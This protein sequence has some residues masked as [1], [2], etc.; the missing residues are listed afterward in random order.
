MLHQ[1]FICLKFKILFLINYHTIFCQPTDN[2]VF[3]EKIDNRPLKTVAF[4][5]DDKFLVV[6]G[7]NKKII[8]YDLKKLKVI[9]KLED[10]LYPV[11][12]IRFF[13][14]NQFFVAIGPN[15]YL[16][17]INNN[18]IVAFRGY[19]TY[20]WSFD[21][22]IPA[23]LV[24][25]GSYASKVIVWDLVYGNIK[26]NLKGH[27]ESVLSVAI[28]PDGNK[29]LTG[30]LDK[31][32]CLWSKEGNLIKKK[33][34]HNDNIMSINFHPSGRYF[35][36][37]S[38]DKT[39]RL[40]SVDSLNILNTIPAEGESVI[41]AILS[42]DGNHV[43]GALANGDV[44]LWHIYTGDLLFVFSGLKGIVNDIALNSDNTLIS[45]VTNDGYIAVWKI[46]KSVYVLNLFKD[47]IFKEIDNVNFLSKD[48]NKRKNFEI[49]TD[50]QKIIDKYYLQ[51]QDTIKKY[52]ALFLSE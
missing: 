33:Q 20:I 1:I 41:K 10:Y 16:K 21:F 51:Y 17:D 19:T 48:N 13:D 3:L 2:I 30:S 49:N 27:N 45:A 32:V 39:I 6:G 11:N 7:E 35:I 28:S 50:F 52:E 34:I 22:N 12:S 46:D 5:R 47:K 38:L 24:I 31:Y 8:F 23:K 18:T 29:L 14:E 42:K 37:A 43:F 25:A 36:T 26:Y 9:N 15:L 40:C 44:C 4:S